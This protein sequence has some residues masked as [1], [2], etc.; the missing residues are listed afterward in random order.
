MAGNVCTSTKPM[1]IYI[2][3]LM[4]RVNNTSNKNID[5]CGVDTIYTV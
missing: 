2:Y 1:H 3:I 4:Q 5:L